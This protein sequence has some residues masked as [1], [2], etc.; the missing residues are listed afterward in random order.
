MPSTVHLLN[1]SILTTIAARPSAGFVETF[2]VRD[3]K[4]RALGYL[5]A[6]IPVHFRG[7]SGSG[8]TTLALHVAAQLDRPVMFL[9]GDEE[10]KTSD[11]VGGDYGYQYRKVVDRFIHTVVKHEEDAT[12]R[13]CDHRLTTACREGH[14]LVYD[15]FTRSHAEANNILLGVLEERVL[16]LPAPNQSE[17][18]VKVHPEFRAIFTSNPQEYAGVHEAQDALGDRMINL[19]VDYFDR[20]SELAISVARSRLA[21]ADVAKIVDLVRAHRASGEYE[22]A[23]TMRASILI[24]RL[25]AAQGLKTSADDARFVQVCLDVLGARSAF[26]SKALAQRQQQRDMLQRLIAHHCP[27]RAKRSGTPAAADLVEQ[28]RS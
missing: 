24:A 1:D 10:M 25:V 22:Q 18:Y 20:E 2:A 8:K 3:L 21:E 11:L 9:I 16:V 6:G 14:T 17:S 12:R 13:W 28:V 15:E 19:D 26:T 4:E 23:P 27:P 7:P 5:R